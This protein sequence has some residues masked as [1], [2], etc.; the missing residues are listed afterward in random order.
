MKTLLRGLGA[1][2]LA[3]VLTACPETTVNDD[4]GLKPAVLKAG[5]WN[6]TWIPVDDDDAVRFAVTNAEQDLLVLTEPGKKE[7]IQTFPCDAE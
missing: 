2:L 4:F 3:C 5:D 1:A 6:G 7:A